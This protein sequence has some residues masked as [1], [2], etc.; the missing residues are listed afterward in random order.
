MKY[1]GRVVLDFEDRPIKNFQLPATISSKVEGLRLEAWLRSDN[2]LSFADIEAR[3]RTEVVEDGKRVPI[4]DKRI[5]SKRASNA[6]KRAGLISWVRKRGRERQTAYMDSLRTQAQRDNNLAKDSDL[7]A[8]Q[9]AEHE[10]LGV[11]RNKKSNAPTRNPRITKLQRTAAT[12]LPVAGP[13]SAAAGPLNPAAAISSDED[14][15]TDDSDVG[16]ALE[17]TPIQDPAPEDDTNDEGRPSSRISDLADSRHD[18]PLNVDEEDDLRRALRETTG[19]FYILTGQQPQPTNP[20]DNYFSQW[21]ML[22]EEFRNVWTTQG[23]PG[24]APRLRARDR[25]T[26][27]ISRYG[28]AVMVAEEDDEE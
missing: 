8:Q 9:W 2:R 26:G 13:S 24:E 1:K 3:V 14:D 7:D 21:G 18:W 22:Q 19:H 28:D 12:P 27:G 10:L 16:E 25:W 6:R 23:N 5:L 11:D 17:E 20:G 15:P 4:F